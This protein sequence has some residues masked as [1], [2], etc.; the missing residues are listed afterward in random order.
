MPSPPPPPASEAGEP[1]AAPHYHGHRQR[2]RQ[3]FLENGPAAVADYE[4]L[5]LVLFGAIP[6]GDVKPLAKRLIGHFGSFA[7]VAGAAPA[8]LCAVDGVG[9]TV[10]ATVK[11]I[12]AAACLMA[13][14]QALNRPVLSNWQ[15][16]V[17]YCRVAMAEARVEQMRLLFLDRKNVLIADELH[18]TGT[19]DQTPLYIREV[20]GRCLAMAACSL[21]LVHNH[22]SGDPT[23]SRADI[24]MTK[25]LQLALKPLE[26]SLHDHL[27]IG[28]TGHVSFKAK[29]LI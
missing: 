3:K 29:G 13:R 9:E 17:D 14:E 25:A 16:V 6:R 10:A 8:E 1:A 24:D 20:V 19:V 5:E 7:A 21:I 4:L 11:A 18:Q 12:Q 28:R 15:A 23:P 26:I 27:V 22:P 2:L